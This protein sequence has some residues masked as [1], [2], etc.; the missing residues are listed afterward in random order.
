MQFH[1]ALGDIFLKC[2]DGGCVDD[3]WGRLRRP[4]TLTLISFLYSSDV[5]LEQ[6]IG[7]NSSY[8]SFLNLHIFSIGQRLAHAVSASSL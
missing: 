1:H 2:R 7:I 5:L 4:G 6:H 8:P 3:G